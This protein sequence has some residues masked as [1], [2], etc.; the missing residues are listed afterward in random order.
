[1]TSHIPTNPSDYYPLRYSPIAISIKTNSPD[2]SRESG[3]VQLS[4]W[5]MT[6]FNRLRTLTQNP[7]PITLPL[8]LVSCEYWQLMFARDLEHSIEI[9][10]AVGFGD[11]GDIIECYKVL[12]ALR[13]LCGWAEDTFLG[14]FSNGVLNPE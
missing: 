12:A 2:G 10:D 7:V 4:I 9:I 8:I 3:V 1:M 11:T 5:A 13:L 6:Y 14:W